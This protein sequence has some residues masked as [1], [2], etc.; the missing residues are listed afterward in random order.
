V[1][2]RER[3]GDIIVV[4]EGEVARRARRVGRE[5]YLKN[6]CEGK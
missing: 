4:M 3:G 5:K 2:G 6:T 1:S